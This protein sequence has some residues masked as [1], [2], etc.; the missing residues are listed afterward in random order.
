MT[1]KK[2]VRKYLR[3]RTHKI[4]NYIPPMLAKETQKPFNDKNWLYEIKWDGYRA[5]AEVKGKNVKL[6][7]RNGNSFN[8]AYPLL[9]DELA[10]M[11]IDAVLDG[12]IVVMD[13]NGIP[14]FQLLQD[15]NSDLP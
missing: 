6:Y 11:N 13:P 15:Y 8:K 5:I 2:N 7:S 3:A 9:V 12:E 4:A 1:V 10:K 14:S